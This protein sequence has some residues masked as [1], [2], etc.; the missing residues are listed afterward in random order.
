MANPEPTDNTNFI[1][2]IGLAGR[3]PGARN[4]E[5]FWANLES[6]TES[7]TTYPKAAGIPES[8]SA[9]QRATIPVPIFGSL[10][11]PEWF[12]ARF[13]GYSPRDTVLIDPQHRVFL[14]CAWE[15]L[16]HAA[17]EASTY[18]GTI[19]IYAGCSDTSYLSI[20][21]SQLS[22]FP[23]IDWYQLT[24]ANMPDFLTTRVSYKIGLTGPSI[25]VLTACSSS[26]VAVHQ[27]CQSLLGGECD[28]ALAGGV[29]LR[30]SCGYTYREGGVLSPDG[31]C[32]A[33]DA[34]ASGTVPADGVGIVVLKRLAEAIAD[35]DHIHAVIRGSAVNNDGADRIGFSAPSINGQVGVIR[36]AQVAAGVQPDTISYVE[37]HG[38]GTQLGDPVEITALAKAFRAGT[39]RRE[40]CALGSVKSNIGHTDA[41]AG[42]AGLIKA[43]LALEHGVLPPSVNFT[44]PNEG[45][46]FSHTP[47][48]VNTRPQDWKPGPVVRR[49][50]VSSFGMGG[51][52][53]H[54]IVEEAP[55]RQAQ[56]RASSPW[57]LLVMSAMTPPAL[58]AVAGN[59]REYLL[60]RPEASLGDV[61]YTLQAGR[62]AMAH[63]AFAVCADREDAIAVLTDEKSGRQV[64]SAGEPR[65]RPIVFMFPGQGAQH[66]G[67]AQE[68]FRYVPEFRSQ[69]DICCD[70]IN[71]HL[72]MDIRVLL[73]PE[74]A[75]IGVA[76]KRLQETWLAQPALF[77]VEYALAR[78]LIHWGLNPSAMIGHS[79][80]ELVAACLAGVFSLEVAA[81]LVVER[82]RLM[83]STLPGAMLAVRLSEAD[84]C[85]LLD[86]TLALAA[87]NGPDQCVVSGP[88]EAIGALRDSLRSRRIGCQ[89]LPVSRAFHSPSMDPVLGAFEERVAFVRSDPPATP[90][91]SG[92]SGSWVTP[93]EAMSPRYWG[94][95]LRE[96]VRFG[97][98]LAAVR[99]E[100]DA[101]LLEVGPGH[102]LTALAR[103]Q[104]ASAAGALALPTLPR[105]SRPGQDLRALLTALGNLWLAGT[106][107]A[108]PRIREH[109][110]PGRIPLPTY[111]FERER[112]VVEPASQQETP[113]PRADGKPGADAPAYP[114]PE[115]GSEFVAPEGEVECAVA[116]LFGEVLGIDRVGS[117]DH[118]FDLGGDSL[119][120]T[121]LLVRIRETFPVPV[122]LEAIFD[123]PTVS[124]LAANVAALLGTGDLAAGQS[125]MP[126]Q[127][128]AR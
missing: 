57:Q 30:R 37:A 70:M 8:A 14:E 79:V 122:P 118:F 95:Q 124:G 72:G 51:T 93:G 2:I 67:M 16:E 113:Q 19:G 45:I 68:L 114:R 36:A 29:A 110:S 87:V 105:P 53:A 59:L 60:K 7:L 126:A 91:I 75:D 55:K 65:E 39:D 120:A 64:T 28:I 116:V 5:E 117:E 26:L 108:W 52:N 43:V 69:M 119:T 102:A 54:V 103:G 13:F 32:R 12:D 61:S 47:F 4:L 49:A 104:L 73:Y 1:A 107:L 63:R 42:V 25:T 33:F 83:H 40:F 85:P 101:I 22:R 109:D 100:P 90:C 77:A 96:T 34:K 21:K 74:E 38:T 106:P 82:G 20:L 81:W 44:R 10:H 17:Y 71:A 58:A 92:V 127:D 112:Y 86:G 115:L 76:A 78:L 97:D 125:G 111:P 3:F 62:R 89:P 80:G 50:A 98:G 27:A 56:S 66:P 88:P 31:H 23:S 18:P 41:A 24:L 123:A 11:E 6:G 121:Q 94:R 15:A 48:F 46:D 84:T 9:E 128:E 35:R 99:A